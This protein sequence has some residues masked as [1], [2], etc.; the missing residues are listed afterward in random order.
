VNIA[1]AIGLHLSSKLLIPWHSGICFLSA[2]GL[3]SIP[4]YYEG[5]LDMRNDSLEGTDTQIVRRLGFYSLI[6]G[7]GIVYFKHKYFKF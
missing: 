4:A 1:S 2:I 6:T 3:N 5:H 7:M